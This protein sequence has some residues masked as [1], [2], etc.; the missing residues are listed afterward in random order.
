[1]SAAAG[2]VAAPPRPLPARPELPEGAD[3]FPRW[4][5]LYGA[6]GFAIGVGG[7]V[8]AA[9]LMLPAL[10]V[11]S[12]VHWGFNVDSD[13]S[14]PALEL[15]ATLFQDIGWV[16]GAVMLAARIRPPHRSQFGFRR[17]RLGPAVGWS[18]VAIASYIAITLLYELIL[19][20]NAS[21][22]ID[23]GQR[24]GTQIGSCVII[25]VVAPLCEE[26]FFRGFLYRIL[27]GRM[28]LWPALVIDGALFGSVHLS[29][30]GPL[31]VAVIAPL[32]FL[33]CLVYERSGSLYPC[34][35]LH[36]LNNAIVSAAE[37]DRVSVVA[38]LMGAAM[39]AFCLLGSLF[40]PRSSASAAI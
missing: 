26:F 2:P 6:Y 31:A 32:G 37:F 21:D 24:L 20:P 1:M 30:G 40:T 14:L 4:P 36:A 28:G 33:L 13:D 12:W 35:A 10:A 15:I 22:P 3:P 27:R 11:I 8:A 38:L 18:L 23:T 16:V 39:L 17:P 34:I 29:S 7:G 25:I 19:Q 9:L 5:A